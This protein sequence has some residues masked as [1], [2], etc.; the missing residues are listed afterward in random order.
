MKLTTQNHDDFT[1]LKIEEARLD[2]ANAPDLRVKVG[3]V[4]EAGAQ[5]IVLDISDV[6]FMDSSSLGAMVS[7][8]KMVGGS[9]DLVVAGAHGI[10]A[11]LFKLT[12]MDKVFRMAEDADGAIDMM[13]VA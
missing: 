1:M 8:L 13:A 4:L 11:D 12:R 2:A 9:G 3:E 6:E 7:I 5:R 10:V